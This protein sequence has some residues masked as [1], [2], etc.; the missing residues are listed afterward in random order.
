MPTDR[1]DFILY[2]ATGFT[3]REALRYLA[4]KDPAKLGRWAVGGR[5]EQ[6]MRAL[7]GELLPG[8]DVGIVV[9]D[10]TDADA[11]DVLIAQTRVVIHLAGPYAKHGELF[12]RSCIRHG[13]HYVDLTGEMPFVRRMVRAHHGAAADA[14]VKIVYTAGF[15]ALPFDL[16]TLVATRE[17]RAR[18]ET[19]CRSVEIFAST[20]APTGLGSGDVLSGGSVNTIREA[21]VTGPE[22]GLEDPAA[23]IE[24][25][26][27]AEAVR[28]RSPIFASAWYDHELREYV[29][30]VMPAP[31]CNPMIVLRSASLWAKA[32]EPYGDAFRYREATRIGAV[33]GRE[34]AN[35]FAA[36]AMAGMIRTIFWVMKSGR[37]ARG[38][39]LTLLNRFGPASGSGPSERALAGMRYRLDTRATGE[40]GAMVRVRLDGGGHP[41][42]RSTARMIVETGLSLAFDEER[43]PPIYGIVTPATGVGLAVLDRLREADIEME[44]LDADAATSSPMEQAE[45]A[46]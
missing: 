22:P 19:G 35:R 6:K 4:K 28:A 16:S 15:E 41:G 2:G 42:Y 30:P 20:D 18:H 25:Q 31:Y 36:E 39:L 44:I 26:P 7:L 32:G 27:E 11:V 34:W 24:D 13:T 45:P 10:S 29:A 1:Y 14:R 12:V 33:G 3:G 17:L 23:L 43:L 8:R 5:N 37:H 21:L 38:F 9:A 40:S 46:A